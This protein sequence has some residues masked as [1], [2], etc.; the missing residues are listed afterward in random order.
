MAAFHP[1]Q[2]THCG[3]SLWRQETFGHYKQVSAQEIPTAFGSCTKTNS[4]FAGGRSMKDAVLILGVVVGAIF[5]IYE[6]IQFKDKFSS[7]NLILAIVAA[8][9]ALI[10]GIAFGAGRVN[11]EE[12]IHITQQ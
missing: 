11:K 1:S 9:V 4:E 5:S 8:V 10:C 7:T 6:F 12:E 3:K 2:L